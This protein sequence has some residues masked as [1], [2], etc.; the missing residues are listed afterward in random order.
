MKPTEL[1]DESKHNFMLW[2]L[3]LVNHV[4]NVLHKHIIVT[5]C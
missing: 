3:F 1:E 5:N 4:Y 2:N